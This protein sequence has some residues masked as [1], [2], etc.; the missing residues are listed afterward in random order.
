M[1]SL[2]SRS[3]YW[4][5]FSVPLFRSIFFKNYSGVVWMYVHLRV[6]IY[7]QIKLIFMKGCAPGLT[8]IKRRKSKQSGPITEPLWN[9]AGKQQKWPTV[10]CVFD[11]T[12]H[13]CAYTWSTHC[14]PTLLKLPVYQNP[15]TLSKSHGNARRSPVYPGGRFQGRSRKN[16]NEK[17]SFSTE[18][19]PFSD[20]TDINCLLGVT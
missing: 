18:M 8:L 10:I 4:I 7:M 3:A 6:F 16:C 9:G 11:L 13:I 2:R 15:P 17:S 14:I 5:L 19:V 20:K 1:S 12:A